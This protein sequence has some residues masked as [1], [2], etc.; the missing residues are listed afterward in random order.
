MR[1]RH[2]T[3]VTRED[4]KKQNRTKKNHRPT[5]PAAFGRSSAVVDAI[6]PRAANTSTPCS[7]QSFSVCR[8]ALLGCMGFLFVS[9]TN[10]YRRSW[11][12]AAR[13]A[14]NNNNSFN[15]NIKRLAAAAPTEGLITMKKKQSVQ[16]GET[17]GENICGTREGSVTRRRRGVVDS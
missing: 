4:G 7:I 5:A 1:R 6:T 17:K 2:V 15:K 14:V 3:N 9:N 8:V 11:E 12:A 16:L 13:A 10:R